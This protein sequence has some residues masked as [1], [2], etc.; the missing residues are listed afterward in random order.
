MPG[1]PQ[2]TILDAIFI[3]QEGNSIVIIYSKLNDIIYSSVQSRS[4]VAKQ[5]MAITITFFTVA[6]T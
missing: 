1:F 5:L 2:D 3:R 6:Q 4:E